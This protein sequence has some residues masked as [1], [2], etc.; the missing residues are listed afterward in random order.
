MEEGKER[1]KD[2]ET[3]RDRNRDAEM[4]KM[5]RLSQDIMGIEISCFLQLKDVQQILKIKGR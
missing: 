4:G 2:R 3:K 1:Q 5:H